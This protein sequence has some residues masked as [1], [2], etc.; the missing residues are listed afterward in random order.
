MSDANLTFFG[1][2]TSYGGVIYHTVTVSPQAE[3]TEVGDQ[4]VWGTLY[5]AMQTVS[6]RVP[7]AFLLSL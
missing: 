7:S 5:Y 4:A 3:F 6:N 1:A 2:V